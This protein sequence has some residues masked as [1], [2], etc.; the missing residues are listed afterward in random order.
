MF[1]LFAG[2]AG[3]G[4]SCSMAVLAMDWAEGRVEQ[5]VQRGGD[6]PE[7][8]Q[9]KPETGLLEFDFVFLIQLRY[10]KQKY[11]SRK[12]HNSTAW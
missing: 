2:E 4:K 6:E 8:K 9:F 3:I 11:T 7:R 1:L 12:S 5:D 10:V